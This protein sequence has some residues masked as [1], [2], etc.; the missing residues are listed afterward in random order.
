MKLSSRFRYGLRL[1]VDLARNYEKG[2]VLLKNI[3]ECE[4]ISKKYLEQIVILLRT[5]GIISAT[6]GAKGGYYLVKD[7]KKIKITDIYKILEGS[8]APVTCIDNPR[9]CTLIRTC[10]TRKLWVMLG[11]QIERTFKNQT[12]ADLAKK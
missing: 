8:F 9:T 7:P 11:E 12:L 1:L 2:P 4:K 6:R 5:A 10:P 3:A